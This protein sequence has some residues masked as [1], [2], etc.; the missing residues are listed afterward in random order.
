MDVPTRARE[1]ELPRENTTMATLRLSNRGLA[2]RPFC[3]TL[4]G[5]WSF[6]GPEWKPVWDPPAHTSGGWIRRIEAQLMQRL[7]QCYRLLRWSVVSRTDD[8]L[9]CEGLY[10]LAEDIQQAP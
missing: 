10:L 8:A 6:G 7:P 9:C 2:I 4:P 3:I 1:D 5:Q